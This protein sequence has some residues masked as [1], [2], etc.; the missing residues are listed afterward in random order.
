VTEPRD[1]I[2]QS[3][4]QAGWQIRETY[5]QQAATIL[6]PVIQVKN[7]LFPY[8]LPC[9]AIDI[10]QTYNVMALKPRQGIGTERLQ[11]CDADTDRRP[12]LLLTQVAHGLQKMTFAGIGITTQ[13][14][15][16]NII[17]DRKSTRLNSS[18]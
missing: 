13:N 10:V 15:H 5:Q 8:L 3:K 4:G 12:A 14:N 16:R 6:Y 11:L 2:R 7:G 17:R 1:Q 9:D 18:H